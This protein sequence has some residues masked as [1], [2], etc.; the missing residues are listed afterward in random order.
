MWAA[1]NADQLAE[2]KAACKARTLRGWHDQWKKIEAERAAEVKKAEEAQARAKVRL[3]DE[4]DE[5]QRRG[6]VASGKDGP[7]A[8]VVD[9]NAKAT[10]ADIGL[11]RDEIHEARA[12]PITSIKA[13]GDVSY[14]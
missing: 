2:A 8:G 10:A 6:E 14:I 13:G 9:G 3:A 4:Y 1:A 11:R 7:G 5:A 12:R